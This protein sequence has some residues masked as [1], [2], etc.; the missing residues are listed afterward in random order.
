MSREKPLDTFTQFHI[1]LSHKIQEVA[2]LEVFNFHADDPLRRS[3]NPDAKQWA[4]EG[5]SAMSDGFGG[6][7]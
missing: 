1:L 7:L 2:N 3:M 6:H 5:V 4:A